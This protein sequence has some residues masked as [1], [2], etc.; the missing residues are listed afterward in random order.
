[1][2]GWRA[3]WVAPRWAVLGFFGALGCGY[4]AAEIAAIQ[5]LG[6]LVGHPVYAVAA[7]LVIFLTCSGAGSVWSDRLSASGTGWTCAAVT[8]L[9]WT[10]AL[11]LL[12]VVHLIAPAAVPLRAMTMLVCLGPLAFLMG[13]PFPLGLR[14]LA[15]RGGALAWAWASNGFA[16]VVA[17]PLSALVSLELGSRVL[18]VVASAA[19]AVAAA[20][21]TAAGRGRRRM[22]RPTTVGLA[23]SESSAP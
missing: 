1:M 8:I 16:S 21:S 4:M 3:R 14:Q 13:I 12:R 5:Q 7:V 9:L 2:R 10:A 6:L 22:P 15:P 23:F 18:L 17:A 20:L 11:V 19:Y